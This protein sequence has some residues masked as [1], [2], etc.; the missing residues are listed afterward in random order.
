MTTTYK[1]KKGLMPL[2]ILAIALAVGVAGSLL[3]FVY[4]KI[5]E[6]SPSAYLCIALAL[7]F[8]CAM[9]YIAYVLIKAMKIHSKS[10]ALIG[11]II[12]CLIF[13]I[14][15]WALYA[16]WDTEKYYWEY[17]AQDDD[18][19][20]VSAFAYTEFMY[21]FCDEDGELL[22]DKQLKKAVKDLQKTS[23]YDYYE[24][25][26]EGG[27]NQYIVD[28]YSYYKETLSKEDL[29]NTSAFDNFY[30][31]FVI[32][33]KEI[34]CI[35]NAYDMD[36][37]EYFGEYLPSEHSVMSYIAHPSDF[38]NKIKDVNEV[39]RWTINNYSSSY[40]SAT[41]AKQNDNYK[42]VILWIVWIGE[43]FFICLPA[44]IIT[45][46]RAKMPFIESENEWATK[47]AS[48][49]FLLKAPVNPNTV[50]K[51]FQANPNS[52]FQYEHLLSRPA[53]QTQYI[54]VELYHSKFYDECY[55][56]LFLTRLVQ[57]NKRSKPQLKKSC[58]AKYVAVDKDFITRFYLHC[59]QV[60]PFEYDQR[61]Y[62]NSNVETPQNTEEKYDPMN[63]FSE[64]IPQDAMPKPIPYAQPKGMESVSISDLA[65]D[66]KSSDE[67]FNELNS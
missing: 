18:D 49:G 67:V 5:N 7:L 6:I 14:F 66:E 43:I 16:K 54:S 37:E 65:K 13:T 64:E 35:K 58:V 53:G 63:V 33:G 38:W 56:S 21:D 36:N 26:Y 51:M 59:Q 19:Y 27:V 40:Y 55:M 31:Y 8:G 50:G 25:Y 20:S 34:E 15:K 57:A 47:N 28:Y 12:G 60:P 17:Y 46:N 11:V 52:I 61:M 2:G 23:T 3:S 41:G 30:K 29:K 9:G 4:L 22:S 44:I 1:S 48:D 42:G 45:C 62:Q 39:G 32:P 10:S 24:D